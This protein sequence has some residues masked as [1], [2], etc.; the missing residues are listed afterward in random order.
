MTGIADALFALTR[1]H[2][3]RA[4]ARRIAC[5]ILRRRLFAW[6]ALRRQRSIYATRLRHALLRT[7]TKSVVTLHEKTRKVGCSF[8][9]H[10]RF[11]DKNADWLMSSHRN[12]RSFR[13][14]SCS[15]WGRFRVLRKATIRRMKPSLCRGRAECPGPPGEGLASRCAA[16]VACASFR[17]RAS[18]LK[19]RASAPIQLAHCSIVDFGYDPKLTSNPSLHFVSLR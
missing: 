16:S 7:D 1:D 9:S 3:S 5:A 11:S 12:V 15:P 13:V 18:A 19:M 2:E 4:V 6:L 14:I 10:A 17:G 8:P